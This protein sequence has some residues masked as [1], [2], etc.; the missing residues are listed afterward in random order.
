VVNEVEGDRTFS[1]VAVKGAIARSRWT[2]CRGRS[3][4]SV[5]AVQRAIALLGGQGAGGDRLGKV[6]VSGAI[7]NFYIVTYTVKLM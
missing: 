4:Y 5:V 7:A 6:G 3:L 2:W 1:V